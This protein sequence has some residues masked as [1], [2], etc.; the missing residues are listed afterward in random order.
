[1]FDRIRS[2]GRM[3]TR[4][5]NFERSMSDEMR[6]HVQAYTDDL[7]RAGLPQEEAARRARIEFGPHA[8]IEEDCREARGVRIA[9]ELRQDLRYAGRQLAKS[10]G[11]TLAAIISLALGIGANSAI[12]G[13]MDA[14]LFRMLPV[15]DP[16]ALYF[17]GHGTGKD[18][19]TSSNYPLLARYQSSGI[20]ESVTSST[21][22]TFTVALP[23][24]L[25]RIDGEFV[26]GNYHATL[27]VRFA[28]GRGFSSEP[29]R[30]DGRAPV[31]V[32]SDGFW[33]RR[34]ARSPDVIGQTLSIGGHLVTIIGVTAPDFNGLFPGTKAE[35]TM[36]LFVRGLDDA[37]FLT[38]RDRWIAVRLVARLRPDRTEAQSYAAA[39][40]L[41]RRY[42]LEPENE[43]RP[44]DVRIGALVAAGK[45]AT[46]LRKAFAT[47]LWLLFAMVATVLLIACTNVANLLLAR[48]ASRAKEVAVRLSLGAGRARLVRQMLTESLLLAVTG[49]VLGLLVA[50]V[51]MRFIASAFRVGQSPLLIDAGL[52]WRVLVFTAAAAIACSLL[53]GLVPALRSSR[54]DVTPVLKESDAQ[55]RLGRWSLGRTLVVTQLALSFLLVSIATLFGRSVLNMRSLDV[56][57]SRAHTLLFD[58]D[59]GDQSVTR[60]E[61]ALF[62]TTLEARLRAW[63]GV[64]AVAY[65]QRSPLDHSTQTRPL[66]IPGMIIPRDSRGVSAN[67]V[68]PDFFRVFGI[69]LVRGRGL[70]AEDRAGAEPVAVVDQT[71]VRAYFA[72]T[73][74]I[75]R[76]VFLGADR[77]P[78]TIVGVVRSARVEDLRDE[79]SRT[80]YTALAQ[81]RLG[82]AEQVGDARRLTV[83]VR[84]TS[85]S[86]LLPSMVRDEVAQLSTRVVVSYVRTM[87]QQFD[88]ALMRER[89]MAAL[90][91][92]YGA[93]ALLLSLVGLYGITAFGVARQT[94]DIG[95]RM[96]L[97]ATRRRVVGG[98]LSETMVT[99]ALGV[100]LGGAAS[101]V[102]ANLV[103]PFLFQIPPQDP[104]TLIGVMALLTV[105]TLF[106][107]YLPGRQ[108]ASIDPVRALKGS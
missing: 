28:L 48:G 21:R 107:G 7:V 40:D 25:Q 74:P 4:R 97:G 88:A 52:T 55:P 108:A 104:V 36:P 76:R 30:P 89:L 31:A 106:A 35:I 91:V 99:T 92:G 90:S 95:I 46:D 78:F 75:G 2:L 66:N 23:E 14:I 22:R 82:S 68:S 38:Q 94:R 45:G 85:S 5:D 87:D 37:T 18:V 15:R 13:L 1:M 39:S 43:R 47:P 100:T 8:A 49:G 10:P 63:P 51:S 19:S 105:T 56:G 69:D 6:F 83:V 77:E 67:V 57:F 26:S 103:E 54:V 20:F 34:F 65:A 27:G 9:D 96:A 80:I 16:S 86:A 42:W 93:L 84:S 12:F 29:D 101:L 17:L 11:F 3:L 73:D 41:F 32:I 58:L 64:A 72:S 44:E 79:P 71:L 102:A 59:A 53:V 62:F 81:S 61:R 98:I 50:H 70:T 24:G 33:E 60:E